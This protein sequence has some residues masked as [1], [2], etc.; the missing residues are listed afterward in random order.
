[1]RAAEAM[2]DG[3]RRGGAGAERRAKLEARTA[4]AVV[5]SGRDQDAREV[6]CNTY[7]THKRIVVFRVVFRVNLQ[8]AE[9]F[10][11]GAFR[12]LSE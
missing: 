1:M 8:G 11:M 2:V 4:S 10:Q 6:S 7:M 3:S 12:V 9:S 5:D